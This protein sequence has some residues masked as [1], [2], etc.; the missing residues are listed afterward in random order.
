MKGRGLTGEEIRCCVTIKPGPWSTIEKS[1]ASII[2][3]CWN[4]KRK[5]IGGVTC[6]SIFKPLKMRIGM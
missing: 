6:S 3:M 1:K 4:Q 2:T 5:E